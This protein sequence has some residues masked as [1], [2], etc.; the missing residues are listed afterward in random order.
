MLRPSAFL[1]SA[2]AVTGVEGVCAR[3]AHPP[4]TTAVTPTATI[5]TDRRLIVPPSFGRTRS[6]A[7]LELLFHTI[8]QSR[9]AEEIGRRHRH[10]LGRGHEALARERSDGFR[11]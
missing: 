4:R 9:V 6:G 10:R 8:E 5:R 3:P 1:R 11:F 7:R 2:L